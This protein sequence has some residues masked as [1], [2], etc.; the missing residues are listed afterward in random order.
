MRVANNELLSISPH[1]TTGPRLR[2]ETRPR[3]RSD[4]GSFDT[5]LLLHPNDLVQNRL[6]LVC[7]GWQCCKQTKRQK[8]RE[9]SGSRASTHH[10]AAAP[11]QTRPSASPSPCSQLLPHAPSRSSGPSPSR[12]TAPTSRWEGEWRAC[13]RRC[14]RHRSKHLGRRP[15]GGLGLLAVRED[16][17]DVSE[18]RKREREEKDAPQ[19]SPSPP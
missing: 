16:K 3:R 17:G 4:F 15:L 19:P 5:S 11:A 9:D 13:L 2:P 7:E 6:V 8:K 12:R 14:G 1:L 10:T 18:R